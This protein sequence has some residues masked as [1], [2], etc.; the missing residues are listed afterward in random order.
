MLSIVALHQT[1]KQASLAPAKEQSALLPG[2]QA[3]PA[4]VFIPGWA[5]GRDAAL[6]V[7]V[8]SSLQQE[9]VRRAAAEVG[10]AAARRHAD[11]MSKY[12]QVCDREG[13][14]FF[15]VVVEALGGWHE[16]AAAL[17]TR[18]AR[19]LASHTG[20]EADEQIKHLF[21]RMG[22][23]LMRGNS[24]LILNRTPRHADAEV[25]GDQDFDN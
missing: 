8:V 16:D 24:A 17:I 20:K 10:S 6:D 23:L 7:T 18:L 11:K 12:F 15:P 4:D 21:Q 22:I 13:I 14:Q 19:Q 2:S 9:L 3:K 5:N 25:D 1:A